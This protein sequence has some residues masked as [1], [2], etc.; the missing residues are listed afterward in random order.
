ML[1]LSLANL[2]MLFL[3]AFVAVGL[4]T[5]LMR[6][7]ALR[8]SV[9]DLPTESHK[10]HDHP[11]PYLGGVAIILGV[12]L[13]TYSASIFSPF[14][15]DTFFLASSIL[16]PALFMGFIGL[17]DDIRKLKPWPRFLTQTF[18]GLAIS[19]FLVTTDTL[20]SPFGDALIDIPL[21][22]LWIVG[23]TNAINFFDNIDGG[24]TGAIAITSAFLFFLS[25]QGGQTLIAAMSLVLAGATLSFLLWN[26][27]PARIYMGD[28]GAL[29]LGV[30][31]A[32]LTTRF[33]P[34][35]I[36]KLAS[37]SIPILLLAIPIMDTT[38]AV[39]S[40]VARGVSPFQ[41]GKDHLSHRLMAMKLSKQK[42]VLILYILSFFFSALAVAISH[43]S[44]S[45][46]RYCML[47]ALLCWA[48]IFLL[49]LRLRPLRG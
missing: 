25:W 23:I 2:V 44:Y 5:P 6:T 10:T 3:S 48:I 16:A 1:E 11:I 37:F 29:F 19:F 13:T 38:V 15:R 47:L 32:S 14:T 24:A 36:D 28:A 34:N 33:N 4:L 39:I 40:R 21:T 8:F 18:F 45:M 35:P 43:A 17:I 7:L 30:L 27:P 26:G 46:E 49:F 41:G 31:I 20:G 9:V 42:S 22:T 12:T